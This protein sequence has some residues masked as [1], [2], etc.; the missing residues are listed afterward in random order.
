MVVVEE[1]VRG[2]S[3]AILGLFFMLVVCSTLG[4]TRE[5]SREAE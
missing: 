4:S 3:C 5:A 1:Y 2:T